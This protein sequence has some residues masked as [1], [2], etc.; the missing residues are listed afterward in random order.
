[1]SGRGPCYVTQYRK[2]RTPYNWQNIKGELQVY[3]NN[4]TVN[5]KYKT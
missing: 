1:M 5:I 4:K 3:Y 2:F